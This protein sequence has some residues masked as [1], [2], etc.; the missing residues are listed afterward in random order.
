MKKMLVFLLPALLLTAAGCI[1]NTYPLNLVTEGFDY[2][3]NLPADGVVDVIVL[4]CYMHNVRTLFSGSTQTAGSHTS[5]WDLLDDSG[6][7]VPGGLYYIRI[8]LDDEVIE[9][10]LYEVR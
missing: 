10:Q 8:I 7:R 9:T 4:N 6:V 1:E 5:S 3:Y 2:S